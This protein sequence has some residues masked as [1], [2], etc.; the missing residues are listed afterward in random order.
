MCFFV[1]CV[2]CWGINLI[3]FRRFAAARFWGFQATKAGFD[4]VGFDVRVKPSTLDP[5]LKSG[6]DR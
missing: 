5:N 6:E 4:F 1:S 2:R 3:D